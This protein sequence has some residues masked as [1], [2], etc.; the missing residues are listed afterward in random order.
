MEAMLIIVM[1]FAIGLILFE[2]IFDE[3]DDDNGV[4]ENQKK[5]N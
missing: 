5:E 1:L 3:E 4:S 2:R